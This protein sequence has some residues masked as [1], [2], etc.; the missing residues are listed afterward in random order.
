MSPRLAGGFFSTTPLGK[1]HKLVNCILIHTDVILTLLKETVNSFTDSKL[2]NYIL[3]S[4]DVTRVTYMLEYILKNSQ[5]RS[6]EID[7]KGKHK[8][9]SCLGS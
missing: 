7:A 4:A 3:V 9:S 5:T 2:F 8:I 6:R 1:P